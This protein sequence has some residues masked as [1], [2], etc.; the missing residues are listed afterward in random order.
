MTRVALGV[1][2]AGALL[3][4]ALRV[5]AV[6]RL[7]P[8][9]PVSAMTG[10]HC[11]GCGTGRAASALLRGDVRGA[12]AFNPLLFL[13]VP[14]VALLVIGEARARRRGKYFTVPRRA[15]LLILGVIVGF[16]VARNLP[17]FG[18]LGP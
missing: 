13:V 9:C 17:G 3:L 11:P 4:I 1:G 16:T 6:T 18:F 14:C 10:L 8:P 2:L 5:S 12:V 7:L 15:V